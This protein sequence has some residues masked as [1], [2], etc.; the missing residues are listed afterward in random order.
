MAAPATGRASPRTPHQSKSEG[1]TMKNVSRWTKEDAESFLVQC[2][3]VIGPGFHPDTHM[4]DYKQQHSLYMLFTEQEVEENQAK[5]EK[6]FELLG[7]QG[8]YNVLDKW[9]PVIHPEFHQHVHGKDEPRREFPNGFTSW[10]ETHYEVVL[11]FARRMDNL[12]GSPALKALFNAHGTNGLYG[13]SVRLTDSFESQNEGETWET[14][15]W[16]D[17]LETCL[18]Q[19]L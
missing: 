8:I 12:D 9:Q 13:A 15:D 2:L 7:E 19:N 11:E 1:K 14:R 18:N 16:R 4:A 5:I 6:A 10:S 3:M 17:E